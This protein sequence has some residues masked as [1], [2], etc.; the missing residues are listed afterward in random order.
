MSN[1][2]LFKNPYDDIAGGSGFWMERARAIVEGQRKAKQERK[3]MFQGL[4]SQ[5]LGG[6]QDIIAAIREDIKK[7]KNVDIAK[8]PCIL[9]T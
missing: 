9:V 2:Y 1:I 5:N 8:K 6:M 3:E 4:N 7:Q